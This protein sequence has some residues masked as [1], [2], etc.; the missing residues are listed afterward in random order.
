MPFNWLKPLWGLLAA[1]GL[2]LI[3][4]GLRGNR[5]QHDDHHATDTTGRAADRARERATQARERRER[6]DDERNP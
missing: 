3:G 1:V 5:G 4:R 2:A 6:A